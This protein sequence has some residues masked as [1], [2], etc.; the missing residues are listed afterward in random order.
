MGNAVAVSNTSPHDDKSFHDGLLYY[1]PKML[2]L[3]KLLPLQ[4]S[5]V[6][7]ID[8]QVLLDHYIRSSGQMLLDLANKTALCNSEWS[9]LLL[10]GDT[11]LSTDVSVLQKHLLRP[12]VPR[13]FKVGLTIMNSYSAG[14]F[15][16]LSP[17]CKYH[18]ITL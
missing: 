17:L 5:D 18:V 3:R 7:K 9:H 12:V 14:C 16:R 10:H 4:C 2:L 15:D 8:V 1:D 13:E 11:V 6:S